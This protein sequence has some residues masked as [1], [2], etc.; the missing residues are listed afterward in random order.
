MQVPPGR[1][2]LTITLLRGPGSS[3]SPPGFDR[4][5][6]TLIYLILLVDFSSK[7]LA[8]IMESLDDIRDC[9]GELGD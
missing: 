1:N 5:R 6:G 7:H 9:D 2:P 3:P 4:G 8:V